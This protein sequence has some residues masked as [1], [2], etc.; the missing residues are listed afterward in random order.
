VLS[1]TADA[2][3]LLAPFS[4]GGPLTIDGVV[5]TY[6]TDLEVT[7]P[8][9][10]AMHQAGYRWAGDNSWQTAPD[11][12]SILPAPGT[13]TQFLSGSPTVNNVSVCP[14]FVAVAPP[15]QSSGPCSIYKFTLSDT[16]TYK[17]TTDWIGTAGAPDIDIYACSD[18]VVSA[19]AFNNNCFEDGGAGATNLKPQATANH[20][21]TAGT[22]Y[23]VIENYAGATSRNLYTTISRP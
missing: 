6:V 4:D 12:S 18:S 16:A 11:I 10:G 21:Y 13:S 17:F 8:S 20:K 1:L 22:H 19:A 23:F 15:N 2:A 7:L 3:T 14:E 5:V 9:A